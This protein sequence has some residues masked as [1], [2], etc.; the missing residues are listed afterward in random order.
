MR[1]SSQPGPAPERPASPIRDG[2]RVDPARRR[3]ALRELAET[4]ATMRRLP[5]PSSIESRFSTRKSRNART[6]DGI[7]SRV[8]VYR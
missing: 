2:N 5:Y 1:K 3:Y 4:R 7:C 6:F 8:G